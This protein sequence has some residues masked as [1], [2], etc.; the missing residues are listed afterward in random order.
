MKRDALNLST[1]N[2]PQL[3]RKYIV[4][5]LASML[6]VCSLTAID[7]IFAGHVIGST[8]IAAINIVVP[9]MMI[10]TGVGL[11]AGIGC[12]VVS[13]AHMSQGNDKPA[14]INITQ[15]MLLVMIAVL[16]ISAPMMIYPERTAG[17]LGASARLQPMVVEYMMWFTPSLL[18][19]ALTTVAI[20]A[21]RMDGSIRLAMICSFIPVVINICLD[22]FFV[23]RMD[24]GLKGIGVASTISSIASCTVAFVYLARFAHKLKL[25]RLKISGTSLVLTCRNIGYQCRIGASSLLNEAAM[26]TLVFMGNQVFMRYLGDDGVGAFGIAC[27]Y[28]PFIFAFGNAVSQTVQTISSSNFQSGDFQRVAAAEQVAIL[29]A[30]ALGVLS[31]ALFFAFPHALTELFINLGTNSGMIAAKGLSLFAV[32]FVFLVVNLTATG[33]FKGTNRDKTAIVFTLLRGFVFLIS[34]FIILPDM[35]GTAG[36][37]LAM[38]ISEV[39]TTM[40]LGVYYIIAK[41]VI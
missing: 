39:L 34:C 32:G 35:F 22:W 10:V 38:P 12:S 20:Y 13:S 16:C 8:A 2:I 19:S 31:T 30:G 3:F 17:L 33:I 25:Y 27:C 7:G 15:A 11:M 6:G 36:I 5:T 9:I 28:V 37:W 4:P 40:L 23:F 24:W 29:V 41:M 21:I 26:A 14:R 18:F 1:M